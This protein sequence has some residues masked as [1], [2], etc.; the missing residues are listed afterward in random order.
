MS[1]FEAKY[2]GN[3]NSAVISISALHYNMGE[4]LNGNYEFESLLGF[5]PNE[6]KG[7][8]VS[9]IIPDIIGK[10][11][12]TLLKNFCI[13]GGKRK[14][15]ERVVL[16][17]HKNGYLVPCF[18]FTQI[19]PNMAKGMQIIG[20]LQRAFY[21]DKFRPGDEYVR[22]KDTL[23]FLLDK[24]YRI[25]GFN[26]KVCEFCNAAGMNVNKYLMENYKVDFSILF[27]DIFT[28]EFINK[29]HS[30][31]GCIIKRMNLLHLKDT[32]SYELTQD[33]DIMHKEGRLTA[34]GLL[35][36]P[37]SI[38]MV[39]SDTPLYTNKSLIFNICTIMPL[40]PLITA[41]AGNS[42]CETGSEEGSRRRDTSGIL[43]PLK[44]LNEERDQELL[45]VWA[46]NFSQYSASSYTLSIEDTKFIREYKLHVKEVMV[47]R[48]VR[49]FAKFSLTIMFTILCL[50]GTIYIYIYI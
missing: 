38:K 12:N 4:I 29:M 45:D 41:D 28:D 39:T 2:G 25:Q 11:H 33:I 22:D 23:L 10:H 9:V 1:D 18:Q 47:P 49:I 40:R 13:E 27:P 30:T 37:V 19:V 31:E 7:E 3:S 36:F 17:K 6:I 32:L 5:D 24:K 15:R 26:R 42:F 46:D 35:D 21:L 8:N 16:A 20:F 43:G 50:G 48:S 34:S 14:T 44:N